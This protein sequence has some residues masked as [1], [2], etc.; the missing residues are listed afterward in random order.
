MKIYLILIFYCHGNNTSIAT[1]AKFHKKCFM[2]QG[3]ITWLI[4][5]LKSAICKFHHRIRW[6]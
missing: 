1:G 5:R 3:T 4:W 2:K 6:F